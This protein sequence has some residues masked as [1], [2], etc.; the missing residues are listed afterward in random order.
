MKSLSAVILMEAFITHLSN[1]RKSDIVTKI[2]EQ[3]MN[4]SM[5]L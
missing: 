1:D 2:D 3:A 4:D 5:H